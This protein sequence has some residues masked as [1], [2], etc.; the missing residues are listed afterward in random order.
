MSPEIL[1]NKAYTE[2]RKKICIVI[3]E[4]NYG[5]LNNCGVDCLKNWD[6]I[7]QSFDRCSRFSLKSRSVR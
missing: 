3:D 5:I 4:H 6:H 1:D 2:R 7:Y